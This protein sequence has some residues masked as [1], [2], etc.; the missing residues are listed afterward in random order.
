MNWF[1]SLFQRVFPPKTIKSIDLS[2]E[3]QDLLKKFARSNGY[4]KCTGALAAEEL[5]RKGLAQW[6]WTKELQ[7]S[8]LYITNR[9]WDHEIMTLAKVMES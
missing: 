9:G 8:Y 7:V 5:V 2:R 6:T 1:T 3:A 4:I